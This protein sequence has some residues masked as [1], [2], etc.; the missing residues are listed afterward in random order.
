MKRKLIM[1]ESDMSNYMRLEMWVDRV[2][3][4]IASWEKVQ[5]LELTDEIKDGVVKFMRGKIKTGLKKG[6]LM[7]VFMQIAVTALLYIKT[8]KRGEE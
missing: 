1:N 3:Q 5:G 4:T 2:E 8:T 6:T 7:R